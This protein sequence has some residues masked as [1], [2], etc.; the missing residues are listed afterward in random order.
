MHRNHLQKNA[1]FTLLEIVII[2][3]VSTLIVLALI[4]LYSG[5]I[6]TYSY[7]TA[8]GDTAGSAAATANEL[9]KWV[10]Q[11][12]RIVTNTTISGTLYTTSSTTLAL[13][14]PSI[15]SSGAIIASAYDY[16]VFY[17]SGTKLY[18]LLSSNAG[19]SR[20]SGTKTLSTTLSS[21]TFTYNNASPTSAD[22]ITV[23]MHMVGSASHQTAA[24][25]LIQKLYL[26]N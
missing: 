8:V 22:A 10:L 26:R 17:S 6:R 16:V 19:S 24:Y 20:V 21:L 3:G 7:T 12:N 14:L 13:E 23:V 5:Y 18:R 15:D 11:S 4:P 2:V 9:Q 1:G 25:E